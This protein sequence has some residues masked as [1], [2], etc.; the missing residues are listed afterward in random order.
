MFGTLFHKE[1]REHLKA[2][3]FG[4]ALVTTFVLVIIS[5]WI[6]GDDYVHRRDLYNSITERYSREI[7]DVYTVAMI[8]PIV[9]HPPSPLGIFATGEERRFGNF[10]RIN[11]WAFPQRATEGLS[12][13]E[14]LESLPTFDLLAVFTLVISLFGVL[15]SYDAICGEKERGTLKLLSTNSVRRGTIFA[16]KFLAVNIVLAL[17]FLLSLVS[18]LIL[19]QFSL[20]I[21]FSSSQWLAVGAMLL[22]GL[23]FGAVFVAV[24]LLCSTLSRRSS[25]ALM[26]ALL[27]WTVG[28]IL[29]PLAG[30]RL[31]GMLVEIP[32]SAEIN[33][34]QTDIAADL[35]DRMDKFWNQPLDGG[36]WRVH[37]SFGRQSFLFDANEYA[38]RKTIEYV[39]FIEPIGQKGADRVGRLVLEHEAVMAGQARLA[40]ALSF[41]S[42]AQQLREALTSL[43]GTSFSA[44]S[45][46]I[47]SARRYRTAFLD[48]LKNKG[49]FGDRAVEF[50]SRFTMDE[51]SEDQCRAREEARS[52][53]S[54]DWYDM[55]SRRNWNEIRPFP[56]DLVPKFG[57]EGD[58]PDLDSAMG[59]MATLA[60]MV[61]ILFALGFVSF[62]RYDIR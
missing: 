54:P 55:T 1:I 38:F 22:T 11:R 47:N 23:I 51:I 26:L 28:N 50:F 7:V 61:L 14:L 25:V 32:S 8:D 29:L 13:N 12:S 20:G 6:L 27:F 2:F 16:V 56:S 60:V 35:R 4:A 57:F 48:N 15:F 58:Q 36:E 39:H 42:P 59:P 52:R 31:A 44:Y 18:A 49:Y 30:G 3:R 21:T 24:G 34:L 43:A 41:I 53:Q 33:A 10:V 62:I 9:W 37:V 46:F 5:V 40:E 19:L 17:P 45:M